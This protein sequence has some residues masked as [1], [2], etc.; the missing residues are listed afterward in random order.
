MAAKLNKM[1]SAK[2]TADTQRPVVAIEFKPIETIQ[3]NEEEEP[4]AKSLYQ[5][6]LE[7][8]SK[9]NSSSL[10]AQFKTK[11]SI[12][13]LREMTEAF[14]EEKER[15][16]EKEEEER[17]L[18]KKKEDEKIRKQLLADAGLDEGES[19]FG[20]SSVDGKVSMDLYKQKMEEKH[21]SVEVNGVK[22]SSGIAKRMENFH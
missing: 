11:C 5:Q 2:T 17:A 9:E 13:L 16:K 10:S 14:E 21:K 22:M 15:R 20:D 3:E 19:K 1:K 4:S 7:S 8:Y 18:A 6:K 12:R